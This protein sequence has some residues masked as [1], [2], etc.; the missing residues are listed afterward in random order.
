MLRYI[1]WE[2]MNVGIS[3]IKTEEKTQHK[4]FAKMSKFWNYQS[5]NM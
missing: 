3:L 2:L 4:K 1:T 5:K